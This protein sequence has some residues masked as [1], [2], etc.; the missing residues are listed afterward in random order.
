MTSFEVVTTADRPDLHE[1]LPDEFR[2]VWPEFIFHDAISNEFLPKVDELFAHFNIVVT[3]GDLVVV[4][5]WGVPLE[6]DH[7]INGLTTL[8][9]ERP[10]SFAIIR[11]QYS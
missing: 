4:G 1:Q 10:E 11:A 9:E 7:T 8:R 2:E 5:G 3:R 6:W